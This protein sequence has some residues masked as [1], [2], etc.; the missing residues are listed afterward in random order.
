[1]PLFSWCRCRSPRTEPVSTIDGLLAMDWDES[2]RNL[3][4]RHI[5]YCFM[6]PDQKRIHFRLVFGDHGLELQYGNGDPLCPLQVDV[7]NSEPTRLF[8][9]G[10]DE[11]GVHFRVQIPSTFHLPAHLHGIDLLHAG[12]L[13]ISTS[14]KG[15]R[16]P[17]LYSNHLLIYKPSPKKN[18]SS[19][20]AK[21]QKQKNAVDTIPN[22]A[23]LTEGA[24]AISNLA[25]SLQDLVAASQHSPNGAVHFYDSIKLHSV[26]RWKLRVSPPYYFQDLNT[27][28]VRDGEPIPMVRVPELERGNRLVFETSQC[29]S[30]GEDYYPCRYRIEIPATE[31]LNPKVQKAGVRHI[32]NVKLICGHSVTLMPWTLYYC[33]PLHLP[34]P[35]TSPTTTHYHPSPL[36]KIDRNI[37]TWV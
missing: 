16:A 1:M 21:K 36:A 5:I 14:E 8:L 28:F 15:V 27:I 11:K 13:H 31:T 35:T 19:Q 25:P 26:P 34:S 33:D 6:N 18:T 4:N 23:P 32:G 7:A 2:L 24:F 12:T 10:K 30:S 20:A 22:E 9:I 17:W 29:I 37:E 3:I